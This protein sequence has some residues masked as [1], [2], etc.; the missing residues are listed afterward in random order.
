MPGIRPL[1]PPPV[2]TLVSRLD[3]L[4]ADMVQE[5]GD[6]VQPAVQTGVVIGTLVLLQLHR[7]CE[8][9]Q[10]TARW[11]HYCGGQKGCRQMAYSLDIFYLVDGLT[12]T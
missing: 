10:Q 6:C 2:V 11:Q 12:V 4:A 3:L 7:L 9:R 5:Q 1:I 8:Q